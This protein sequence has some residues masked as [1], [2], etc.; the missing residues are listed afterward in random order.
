M[1]RQLKRVPLDF[2]HPVGKIW[3]GFLNPHYAH[4]KQCPVCNGDG[5]SPKA[6]KLNDKWYGWTP[7]DPAE[8][9]SVPFSDSHPKILALAER[10]IR[11]SPDHYGE[12]NEF[13]VSKEARRLASIYNKGWNHHLHQ[14]DVDALVDADRLFDFTRDFVPG[15]GWIKKNPVPFVSAK[16]VNE[17]S[18][19]GFG[20]D[21]I[22]AGIVIRTECERLG[23]ELLCEK[24]AGHGEVW[25]SG[26]DKIASEE[27]E[28]EEPPT[29]EAY[30]VWETVSEGSPISPAFANPEELAEWLVDNRKN[31]I[32][33]GT[34][35][36]QWMKFIL[37]P[38]WSCSLVGDENGL[39]SGV[40][41]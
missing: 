35:K 39:R 33:D 6:K 19:G 3:P 30:Q 29:G 26:A 25:R 24:C 38:G 12:L 34:T 7:F 22:N 15:Q 36:E 4:S 1:G 18:L 23:Y 28:P 20:H 9:E 13:N 41:A 16:E 40:Q 27:W 5:Y 32:D 17:W 31:S 10:N 37:G 11:N 2:P 8:K 21:A 14:R